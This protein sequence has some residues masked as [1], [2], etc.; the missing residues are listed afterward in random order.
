M[1]LHALTRPSLGRNL[2]Y[3]YALIIG[4]I[5]IFIAH[6]SFFG[7]LIWAAQPLD[8]W[9][10]NWLSRLSEPLLLILVQLRGVK[11]ILSI[12][13]QAAILYFGGNA[14][15]KVLKKRSS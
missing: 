2:L 9:L 11:L 8:Y 14:L 4:L 15:E 6:F 12:L 5:F 13:V 1:A 7:T 10:H 3:L